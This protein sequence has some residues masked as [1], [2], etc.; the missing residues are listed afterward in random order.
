[1]APSRQSWLKHV[2]AVGILGVLSAT[3]HAIPQDVLA[4]GTTSLSLSPNTINFFS[5]GGAGVFDVGS[6]STGAFSALGGTTGMFQNLSTG[7]GQVGTPVSV[8]NF[9]TI[10]SLPQAEFTLTLVS[11]G[12][13][14]SAQ[15]ALA[16]AV[17][18]GCTLPGS[19]LNWVNTPIATVVSFSASGTV[20]NTSTGEQST[21]SGTFATQFTGQSFQQVLA[22]VDAGGVPQGPHSAS[23]NVP[24]GSFAGML[25]VGQPSL[26]LSAPIPG[27]VAIGFSPTDVTIG[28]TSTGA[29]AALSG[30]TAA[31]QNLDTA[32]N[33]VNT[34]F[35]LP[36][37]LTIAGHPELGFDLTFISLGIFGSAQ[38]AL[39]PAVG[40]ECT[41]PGSPLNFINTLSG[42]IMWFS[43]EGTAADTATLQQTPF[44]ATF[45]TEFS[46]QSYQ[47]L[48]AMLDS[49]ASINASYSVE[50]AA[51]P[52]NA[53]ASEPAELALLGVAF[54]AVCLA[55]RRKLN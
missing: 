54:A 10:P 40:Q 22:Q 26:S 15:C 2:L 38:C 33:P 21:F 20:L 6:T 3:V 39:A 16:P 45:T 35:S 34:V 30:M 29:F 8:P 47:Q 44:E 32:V 41:L 43:V 11:P 48:L 50:F 24:T 17:G 49:G 52:F 23:I 55:K 25:N 14:G 4:I 7:P 19:P 13:F 42:T 51:G 18:Q 27:A 9:L 12:I 37:F 28:S 31:L 5:S 1:M 36:D 46:G 53:S